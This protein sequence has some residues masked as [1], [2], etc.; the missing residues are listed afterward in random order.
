VASRP[1]ID[2]LT[3]FLE[4]APDP[5]IV[6]D[7]E[8]RILVV[9]HSAACLFGYRRLEMV[10]RSLHDLVP[11]I[12]SDQ[13][14]LPLGGPEPVVG[15]HRDGHSLPLSVAFRPVGLDAGLLRAAYFR[16]RSGA[17][18]LERAGET[19]DR[20]PV[21]VARFDPDGR[22]RYAN[23]AL[24]AL[25]DGCPADPVGVTLGE[26]GWPALVDRIVSEAVRE[27]AASGTGRKLEF[28][29]GPPGAEQ[30]YAGTATPERDGAGAVGGVLVALHNVTDR[31]QAMVALE[32]AKLRFR[33]VT[34]GSQ[35]LISQHGPDGTFHYA[36]PAA[37]LILGRRPE[38]LVGRRLVDFVHE[39]DRDRLRL[40][41]EKAAVSEATE[42]ITFRFLK[43]GGEPV[44]C[45][46]TA[47]WTVALAGGG[48]TI[49]CIT[50]DVTERIRGEEILRGASRM[51]ATATLAAGVAHDFNNLMTAILGNAELL[52]ADPAFPDAGSRLEQV[53]EAAKRGGALAQQLLAYARGG[54]YQTQV[55]SVNEVVQQALQLQK[56]A[57]PPRI[58]LE[59]NLDPGDPHVEG[60]PVQ[61]G[62]VLTNLC[63][64][65]CEATPGSGR[66]TVRTRQ[67]NLG[68]AEVADKPGLEGGPT[69]LIQVADTGKGIEAAVLSRIFEPF[70]STKFQGRGL[71]LAAAYGIVKN[72]RGYIG[73][74]SILGTGTTFS[75][76]LPAVSAVARP[77]AV[78]QDPFPTGNETL[79]LV[80]DD[81]AV[82]E[83]TRSI[84]ERLR[85]RVLVARHGIEAVEI[86]RT[87]AGPI[88]L[89]LLDMGMPMAGGAEAFPFLK[90]ARPEM[91][92]LISSGYEMDEVVQGLVS[93]GADAFLQKP[94]RV[95]SLARGIRRV[96]DHEVATTRLED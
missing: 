36:S 15:R 29:L 43:P 12:R 30:W 57:M 63:I 40:C 52:L 65:A 64:N 31:R 90:A 53:A 22:L 38:E 94:Y 24:V 76:Y 19:L 34:E 4:S 87:F 80:D 56:H 67:L 83:V 51:E 68:A 27:S 58:Q 79:L 42:L 86:V 70:F 72:H 85:Y 88:D 48:P 16:D 45:E 14:G 3:T 37:T 60:D 2:S 78:A 6:A 91:R 54:K 1:E 32:S 59:P 9:N 77:P 17:A 62:Q 28:R 69:V 7:A 21:A 55:V 89:V 66:V 10:G 73:V 44:C 49:S 75:I 71:G 8:D 39:A 20:L 13:A 35:D 26:L 41:L 95:S 82:I 5:A 61:I 23:L 46:M 93:A 11:S 74:E 84:L 33:R 50:R 92:I 25:V 18:P 81:E 96:L 47:H